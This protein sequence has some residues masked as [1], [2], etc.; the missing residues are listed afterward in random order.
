[1]T[2]T[3][4][5]ILWPAFGEGVASLCTDE[6]QSNYLDIREIPLDSLHANATAFYGRIAFDFGY[7]EWRDLLVVGKDNERT[8]VQQYIEG[9]DAWCKR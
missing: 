3:D 5:T 6:T 4:G 9:I 8:T 2:F 1:M 7:E